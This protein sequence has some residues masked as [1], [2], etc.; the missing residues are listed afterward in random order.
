MVERLPS[1]PLLLELVQSERQKQLGHFDA[2]DGKA[3][4]V[5]GFSGLLVTLSPDAPALT[6]VA[7]VLAATAAAAFAL[8]SFWPRRFPTMEPT[9]LRHYLRAEEG[10]TQLT[11]LDTLED[12]VN[13]GSVVLAGKA[14]RLRWALATLALAAALFAAGIVVSAC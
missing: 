2:L 10:F 8:A 6:R 13:E 1:L 14:R 4:I 5:L 9:R 12:F 3:G 7:G 11:V